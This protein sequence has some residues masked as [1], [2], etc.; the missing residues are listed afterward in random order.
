MKLYNQY[1][2]SATNIL[3]SCVN[4]ANDKY[5]QFEKKYFDIVRIYNLYQLEKENNEK[6]NWHK[7]QIEKHSWE[8]YEKIRYQNHK[9]IKQCLPKLNIQKSNKRSSKTILKIYNKAIVKPKTK[10]A[11]TNTT[12]SIN[13]VLHKVIKYT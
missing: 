2:I 5:L 6:Q 7:D 12:I 10:N 1:V 8:P 3:Q 9:A 4:Q 13:P 11:I